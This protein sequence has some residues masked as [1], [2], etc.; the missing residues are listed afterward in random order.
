M[1]VTARL[2]DIEYVEIDVT[3]NVK[4]ANAPVADKKASKD[5]KKEGGK[6]E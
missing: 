5:A 1:K 4:P 2:L 3:A 6:A